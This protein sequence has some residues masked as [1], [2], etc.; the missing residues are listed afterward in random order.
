[1]T[2]YN[3]TACEDGRIS[4]T[5][6]SISRNEQCQK[7]S[8]RRKSIDCSFPCRYRSKRNNTSTY[9]VLEDVL[10][11]LTFD[12]FTLEAVRLVLAAAGKQSEVSLRFSK[13]EP[14]PNLFL[15]WLGMKTQYFRI[16]GVCE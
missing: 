9:E 2:A 5:T 16:Q 7:Y 13:V 8:P 3:C 11:E 12:N 14:R 1:M 4:M 6:L 15:E 10:E